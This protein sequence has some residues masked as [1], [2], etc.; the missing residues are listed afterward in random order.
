MEKKKISSYQLV[1]SQFFEMFRQA[2]PHVQ[3]KLYDGEVNLRFALEISTYP[4]T[5]V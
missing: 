3:F 4:M 5:D 2:H 1:H